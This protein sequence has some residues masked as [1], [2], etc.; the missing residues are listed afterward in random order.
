MAFN[1][2]NISTNCTSHDGSSIF[3]KDS[4]EL[5]LRNNT[6]LVYLFCFETGIFELSSVFQL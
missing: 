4:G 3:L 2:K 6:F 1:Q 5:N